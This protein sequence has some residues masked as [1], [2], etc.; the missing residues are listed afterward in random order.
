MRRI[1]TIT[2][3]PSATTTGLLLS[4]VLV[5]LF[6]TLLSRPYHVSA[7]QQQ[8]EETVAEFLR[9]YNR[10]FI[11]ELHKYKKLKYKVY[12]DYTPENEKILKEHEAIH[13]PIVKEYENRASLLNM[14]GADEESRRQIKFIKSSMTSSDKYV[15]ENLFRIKRRMEKAFQD[16]KVRHDPDIIKSITPPKRRPGNSDGGG[17]L[18]NS[19]NGNSQNGTDDV[20]HLGLI[21]MNNVMGNLHAS[22]EE[23]LYLWK[24]FRDA[25][26][27]KVRADYLEFVRYKNLA[28]FENGYADAGEYKR[29]DYEVRFF[30]FISFFISLLNLTL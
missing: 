22:P 17:N 14:T 25:L 8:Q 11:P 4:N 9:E 12:T 6:T 15:N 29:R 26:G 21:H 24:G 10:E 5:L 16:A 1:A 20:W 30:K 7:A 28:A 13:Q 18:Q 23:K 27:P 19:T 2:A 3:N